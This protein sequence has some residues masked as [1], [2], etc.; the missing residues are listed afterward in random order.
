MPEPKSKF[1]KRETPWL[2]VIWIGS[3]IVWT[4]ALLIPIPSDYP[5]EIESYRIDLKLALGKTLHLGVYAL[6]TM[7]TGLLKVNPRYRWLL[8]FF[9]MAHASF[10]EFLQS[11]GTSRTGQLTDVLLN[12]LGIA[13]GML[14][15]W[16]WWTATDSKV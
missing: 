15:S 4:V 8:M 5:L 11:L 1:L 6:L 7:L 2:W 14:I 9:L 3:L 13:L 12:H 16:R 10:T